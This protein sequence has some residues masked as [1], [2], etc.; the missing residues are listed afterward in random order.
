MKDSEVELT[1][2]SDWLWQL[3]EKE[4]TGGFECG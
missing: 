3:K 2:F 1:G 4:M